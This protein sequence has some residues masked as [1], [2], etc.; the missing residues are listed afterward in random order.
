MAWD[1]DILVLS[2]LLGSLPCA[3]LLLLM[4]S[5]CPSSSISPMAAQAG[6]FKNFSSSLQ[7]GHF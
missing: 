3:F 2:L 6:I 7:M 1:R 5:L 4:G